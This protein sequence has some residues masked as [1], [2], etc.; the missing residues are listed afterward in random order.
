MFQLCGRFSP[1]SVPIPTSEFSNS[2]KKALI[3]VTGD[4]NIRTFQPIKRG[5]S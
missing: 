3:H 2:S 5:A 1:E 4:P